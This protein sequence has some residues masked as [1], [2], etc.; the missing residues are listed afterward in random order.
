LNVVGIELPPL[1]LR[2]NDVV[3][4]AERLVHKLAQENRRMVDGLSDAARRKIAAYHWPGNLPELENA[5]LSAVL[6]TEGPFVEPEALP[7]Q[8]VAESFETLRIPGV[9][10]AEVER[11]VIT[12]TFEA[13]EQSSVRAAEILE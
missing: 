3:A 6:L 2:G 11:Y 5:V 1:R 12:K 8:P 13:A 10:M 9:T 4:L 7:F